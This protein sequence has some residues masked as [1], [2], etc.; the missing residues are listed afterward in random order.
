MKRMLFIKI[1]TATALLMGAVSAHAHTGGTHSGFYGGASI[2]L[3]HLSG[4][5]SFNSTDTTAPAERD[6][7]AFGL[8]A[9]SINGSL[10]AGYGHR[11][12]CVLLATELS[13]LF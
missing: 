2:G 5:G 3:S 7:R 9:S 4:N 11:F 8:S 6:Q 12:N 10:F 1:G 13:F